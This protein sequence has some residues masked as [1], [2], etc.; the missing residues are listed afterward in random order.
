MKKVLN[1]LLGILMVGTIGLAIFAAMS[2]H[3]ENPTEFDAS[4]N[5]NLIWG[6]A[7]F[8]LAILSAAFCAVWG[9][10]QNPATIKSSILS[11]LLVVV[12]IGVAY[13]VANGHDYKIVNLATNDFFARGETVISDT[14]ILVTYVAMAVAFISAI[15]TEVW[16]AFK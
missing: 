11:L 4:I 12:I 1:I 3:S 14:S 10:A 9:M 13:F 15:A 16:N 2:T 5:L 8:V 6:Y 7:L